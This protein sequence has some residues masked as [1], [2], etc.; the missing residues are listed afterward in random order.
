MRIAVTTIVTVSSLFQIVVILLIKH[1]IRKP[2]YF[3]TGIPL[4]VL[5][6]LITCVVIGVVY[7]IVEI[8]E[9]KHGKVAT[10]P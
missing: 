6:A 9:R 2:Q 7:L 10:I 5:L 4:I 8:K 3:E 1:S